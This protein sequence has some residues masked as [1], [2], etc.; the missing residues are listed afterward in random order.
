MEGKLSVRSEHFTERPVSDQNWSPRSDTLPKKK[1]DFTVLR[2]FSIMDPTIL[3]MLFFYILY[4]RQAQLS[5]CPRVP[6]LKSENRIFPHSL[7][8]MQEKL[9]IMS[10]FILSSKKFH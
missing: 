4:V 7:R 3:F 6:K 1:I 8:S 10:F 2:N 9:Y 5:P